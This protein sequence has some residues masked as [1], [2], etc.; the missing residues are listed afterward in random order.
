MC[1]DIQGIKALSDKSH[2][3]RSMQ[4]NRIIHLLKM[5]PCQTKIAEKLIILN[6]RAIGMLTRLY[7]IK[8]ACCDPKSK[9]QLLNEKSLEGCLKHITRKFPIIDTRSNPSTFSQANA[10]KQEIIKSL[11]LYY[12]TFADLLDLK[13]HIMQLLTAMDACQYKLDI[14]LNYDLTAGYMNLVVNLIC[15]MILVS[16]VDDRRAVLGLYNAAFELS[17]GQN[18]STFPRLGQMILDY[19]N[20]LK[21]LSEDLGPLNRL[22]HSALT[23][24]ASVYV[25]RNITAEAWRNAQM[26]SLVASPQQILY[27]AQTDTIACEYLSLDVMDRWIIL[28]VTVCHSNLLQ[29]SVIAN[30]WQ[31]ALQTGLAI[32]LFR[33]EILIVHQT[34]QAFFDSIKGYSRKIQEVK[35]HYSMALQT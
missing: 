13:D 23:S 12:Y 20:P 5:D 32:R 10:L 19:E 14:T 33:D 25:R 4:E 29:D 26:L 27:A 3:W 9:P 1:S 18:E 30:L 22:I 24:L 8:R 2:Y 16:R 17:N 7:N 34:V 31:R 11:S 28:G 21:K 6:D 15:M 35:D